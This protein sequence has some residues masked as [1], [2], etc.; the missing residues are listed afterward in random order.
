MAE[1]KETPVLIVGAGPVGI[2][3]AMDLA[4]RG[5]EVT[6]VERR[7]P[8]EPPEPKCNHV[9]ARS[10]EIYRR[11]GIAAKLRN[12]GLPEDYPNDISYRTSFIGTEFARIHIPC[13]R[14]RFTDKSGPD[15]DWPTPE[16]PHRA[17]QIFLEPLIFE[18]AASLP[19]VT[20]LNRTEIESFE[21][22]GAEIVATVRNLETGDTARI[23][24]GYLVGCDG[25]RSNRPPGHQCAPR[26][27]RGHSANAGHVHSRARPDRSPEERALMDDEHGES[28]PLG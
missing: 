15:G 22:S 14:D 5:I 27:R 7:Q 4:W 25:G 19:R 13:R 18:H 9:S 24:C 26:G 17:N 23:A 11:L 8:G 1:N 21:Q 12:V 16:P 10:M 20:I 3:L 6:V 28:T 2:T